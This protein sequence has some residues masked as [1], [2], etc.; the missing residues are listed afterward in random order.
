MI[1]I[2]NHLSTGVCSFSIYSFAYFLCFCLG[3]AF[4]LF[5]FLLLFTCTFVTSQ[6]I[7]HL[8]PSL[9][10]SVWLSALLRLQFLFDFDEI[11]YTSWVPKSKKAFVTGQNPITPSPILPQFSPPNGFSMGRSKCRT[12]KA[13]SWTYVPSERLQAQSCKML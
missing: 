5:Y 12:N 8:R 2:E 10:L 6:S 4:I 1:S 3:A 7:N 9:C 11:L 13:Y